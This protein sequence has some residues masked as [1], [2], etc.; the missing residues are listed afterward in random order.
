MFGLSVRWSLTNAPADTLA[1]LRKYVEEESFAKFAGLDGLRFK[2]WGARE[3][4]WFEGRYVFVSADAREKFQT[5]FEET[6]GGAVGTRII[7]SVP[8][9]I[10]PFEVVAVVRG[11]AG[12]RSSAN[13]EG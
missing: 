8:V 11:P 12:F 13:F 1:H 4:E 7:G 9:H 6:V 2:T 3:G 10:E 5:S